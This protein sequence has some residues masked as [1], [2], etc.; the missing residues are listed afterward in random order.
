[1][2]QGSIRR[3]SGIKLFRDHAMIHQGRI[4]SLRRFK[5]EVK[6]VREGYECG[7]VLDNYQAIQVDDI[8]EAFDLEEVAR[9][10]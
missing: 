5:D 10:L 1:M 3:G 7:I 6:E 9:T 4:K 8:I 2:A